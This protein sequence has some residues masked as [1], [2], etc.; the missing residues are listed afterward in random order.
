[1][2]VPSS[3]TTVTCDSPYFD[4]ERVC[5]R[6]GSPFIRVSIGKVMRCSTSKGE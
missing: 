2:S 3:N 4:S 1:M 5:S 6:P